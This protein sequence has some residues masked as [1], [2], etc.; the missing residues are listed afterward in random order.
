[1]VEAA[2]ERPVSIGLDP[3]VLSL[4]D[5]ERAANLAIEA[6]ARGISLSGAGGLPATLEVVRTIRQLS[7]ENLGLKVNRTPLDLSEVVTLIEAGATRF[8]L[9]QWN[10]QPGRSRRQLA[11][12]SNVRARSLFRVVVVRSGVGLVARQNG[13]VARSTQSL[14]ASL[15][16]RLESPHV[17]SYKG[18]VRA[19]ASAASRGG[20]SVLRFHS[21]RW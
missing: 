2:D 5:I 11:A 14:I 18:I 8:G 7:P 10:G 3:A 1:V 21:G 12:E 17:A 19:M 13:P 6:D 20:S 4:T 15:P 9:E 16:I